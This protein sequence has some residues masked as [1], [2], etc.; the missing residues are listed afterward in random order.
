MKPKHRFMLDIRG[1]DANIN[2]SFIARV[3]TKLAVKMKTLHVYVSH[4]LFL[5]FLLF[6]GNDDANQLD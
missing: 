2:S 5:R 1:H 3:Y 4:I 6:L